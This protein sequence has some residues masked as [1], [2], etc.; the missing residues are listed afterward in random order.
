MSEVLQMTTP[1]EN[2]AI[3]TPSQIMGRLDRA[4]VMLLG[5]FHFDNPGLDAL[6]LNVDMTTPEK[7]AAIEEV[8]RLLADFRPTKIAVE[9]QLERDPVLR[10]RY[11][12]YLSG[13]FKLPA[14][15]IYQLGFQLAAR[16]GHDRVYPIDVWDRHYDTEEQF[17]AYAQ[18]R[19]Y[20][21]AD[22]GS[23][24]CEPH[25][26]ERYTALFR[27]VEELIA[28]RPLREALAYLNSEEYIQTDHGLYLA[29]PDAEPGDYTVVD[30][31][32][33]WFNRNLRIFANLKRITA[34]ADDR[35]LVIYGASHLAL[36][37]HALQASYL[38]ELT[39]VNQYLG[40]RS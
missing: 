24:L 34:S 28:T 33:G 29:W 13:G 3:R 35:I 9:A 36:L 11:A 8:V 4:K 15:E 23:L 1:G 14:N 40:A 27:Y 20:S 22:V 10:E 7:Q 2:L 32:S 31:R 37:R 12:A 16:C 39:D 17:M 6:N 30:F 38:H 26:W 18:A 25:W 5:T 19:G 21:E